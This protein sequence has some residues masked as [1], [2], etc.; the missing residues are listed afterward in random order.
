MKAALSAMTDDDA[1]R[2][3]HLACEALTAL[4]EFERAR[5]VM[6]Y[7]PIP[8]EVDVLPA[9][10]DAWRAGKTVV[11]PKVSWKQRHMI[12]VVCESMDD[13][14][15][16]DNVGLRTPRNGRPWPLED[17]DLV[18]V[19]ALAYDRSGNRLGR[20]GGFYDRFLAEPMVSAV[21]AGLAFTQQLLDTLPVDHHDRPVDLLV[22]ADTVLRPPASP[23]T[24]TEQTI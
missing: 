19:P 8:G 7:L 5:A 12:P 23:E 1:R 11:V 9:G 20:G 15:E 21:T 2:Q 4:P 24:P 16:V 17:V 18:V 3:S 6:L 13:E 14:F 10:L 22:T